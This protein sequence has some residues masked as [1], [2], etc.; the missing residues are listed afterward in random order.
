MHSDRSLLASFNH[1]MSDNAAFL[2]ASQFY[3][4]INPDAKSKSTAGTYFV[5]HD[6]FIVKYEHSEVTESDIITA[7]LS[8]GKGKLLRRY[9]PLHMDQST[10]SF[11]LALNSS[12]SDEEANRERKRK[13]EDIDDLPKEKE[14]VDGKW[15]CGEV[16]STDSNKDG[17]P[18]GACSEKGLGLGLGL[19]LDSSQYS[20][21]SFSGG[22][23]FI[24]DIEASLKPQAGGMLSFS[25]DVLHGG[26]PIYS[27][28]RYIVA[29]FLMAC[30]TDSHAY[31]SYIKPKESKPENSS[32][33]EVISKE[34]VLISFLREVFEAAEQTPPLLLK[35]SINQIT[36]VSKS[37]AL[38]KEKSESLE[39]VD[40]SGS[41]TSSSNT[42]SFGFF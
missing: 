13:R 27:G 36:P 20:S 10:H 24:A 38:E 16:F 2:L 40:G 4:Q 35:K 32:D 6:A 25:G 39:S 30:S 28:K 41:I 42:F 22:G 29:A 1:I 12:R 5:I 9:L 7:A 17:E 37:N 26:D 19:G 18:T 33:A 23:T 8:R 34:E 21:E 15:L 11:V 3:H 14:S 31:Q